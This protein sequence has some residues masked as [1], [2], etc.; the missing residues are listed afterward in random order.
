[1]KAGIVH[2]LGTNPVYGDF[3]NPQPQQGQLVVNIKAAAIKQVDRSKVAGRHYTNFASLPV[4]PGIDGVGTL[5]NGDAVYAWG[6][7]GMFAEQAVIEDG[8]CTLLPK[9]LDFALAAALPNALVGSDMALLYRAQIR[10]GQT[11]LINGATGATGKVAVQTAKYRGAQKVIVTGRNQAVLNDL[12]LLGADEIILLTQDDE[13]II[14]QIQESHKATPIDIVID[15]LW[16]HPVELILHA[17]NGLPPHK[18][19]MV[20]V[21]E[22]AGST[23]NLPSG[24]LRSRMVQLLGSG[25]GSLSKKDIADYLQTELPAIFSLAAQGKLVMEVATFPLSEI[26]S[27]WSRD[28]TSGKRNVI[29]ME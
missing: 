15:Y 22:M 16:G 9:G 4:V 8:R 26:E 23:I 21:G 3:E 12:L 1:M 6:L 17:I 18:I 7:T 27:V 29:I 20:T 25:I 24:I 11:V 5:P 14:N 10:V 28:E 19:T 13:T 2:Q